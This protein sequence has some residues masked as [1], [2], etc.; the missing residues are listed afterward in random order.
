[1]LFVVDG[2]QGTGIRDEMQ[3]TTAIIDYDN[4]HNQTVTLQEE[5]VNLLRIQLD[6]TQKSTTDSLNYDCSHVHHVDVW[7]DFNDDGNFDGAENRVDVRSPNNGELPVGTYDLKISIPAIDGRRTKSGLHRMRIQVIPSDDHISKCGQSD[8]SETR[9]Y[10]VNIIPTIQDSV[11]SPVIPPVIPNNPLCSVKPARIMYVHMAGQQGTVIRDETKS[12]ILINDYQKLHHITATLYESS[13]TTLRIQL[14]CTEQSYDD[15]TD[16]GCSLDYDID[17]SIDLNDD[18][19]FDDDENRVDDRSANHD[20]MPQGTYDFKIS[21]PAID[22]RQIKAGPHRMRLRLIPSE[23]YTRRC[24]RSDYSEIREYIVNIIPTARF[25]VPAVVSPV[26]PSNSLCSVRPARIIFVNMVGQQGTEIRDETGTN[27][28]ISEHQNRHHATVTLYES[29]VNMLRINLNCAEQSRQDLHD[30]ECNLNYSI[31]VWIDLND[32]GIFDEIENRVLHRSL[33]HSRGPRGA[34]DL[35]ICTPAIDERYA[36]IGQHRMRLSLMVNDDYRKQCGETDYSET[37]EYMVNIV[38]KAICEVTA[39]ISPVRIRNIICSENSGKIMLVHISGELGTQLRDETT[40]IANIAT[41]DN[42]NRHDFA[43]TLYADA[44]YQVRIQLDCSRQYDS[45][46]LQ[47]DCNFAHHVNVWIDLNDDGQFDESENRIYHQSS[48]N[49]E[50]SGD[51]YDLQIF[52]PIIDDTTTKAGQ[53]RMRLS[54][55]RSEAYR[56][57]CGNADHVET[58]EY[59]VKIIPRKICRDNEYFDEPESDV[60]INLSA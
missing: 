31:D 8:Y 17:V 21:I 55:T 10:T 5:T 52:I 34:Y 22:G 13:V 25:G 36:R 48:V 60:I 4:R 20:E 23:I 11:M 38:P 19:N 24:G 1:M 50:T 35:E 27:Y 47:V 37:R 30:D 29:T 49:T 51:M 6:C 59:T 9:E 56:R 43:V 46:L 3:T 32:D 44:A 18:G 16:N 57:Q 39:T 26:A 42:R 14:D 58:R 15:S 45:D 53:H 2:E 7:I 28:V 33:M 41:S 40:T 54:V 12:D